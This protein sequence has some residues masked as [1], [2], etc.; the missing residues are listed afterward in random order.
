LIEL[1]YKIPFYTVPQRSFVKNNK[2]ALQESEFVCEAIND[3]LDR[4]LIEKCDSSGHISYYKFGSA[5][6][7]FFSLLCFY[8]TDKAAY[9]KV[10][11]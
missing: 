2:S 6:W 8:K 4:A 11:G 9:L 5:V 3:L 1:G 7:S 10:E